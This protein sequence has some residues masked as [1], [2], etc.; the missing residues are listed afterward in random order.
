VT[1]DFPDKPLSEDAGRRLD[2]ATDRG[3]R[4]REGETA[5]EGVRRIAHGRIDAALEQLRR[6]SEVDVASA[7]HDTRKDLKKLRSLLRLVRADLGKREYR[8][9]NGRY[10]DAARLLAVARDAEVKLETLASLRERYPDEAPAAEALQRALEDERARVAGS[11]AAP[12]LRRRLD[13][14]VEAIAAGAAEVDAWEFGDDGFDLLRAGL[15]RSYRRGRD[16]MR[17]LGDDPT[18]FELHEWRKRVKDLWYQLRLLRPV[19]PAALKGPVEAADELADLLGDHHDLALLV[20]DDRVRGSG[21]LDMAALTGL[22]RRRQRE[23][24][25]AALPLGERLYAEKPKRFVE[26]VE[27]Y[28]DAWRPGG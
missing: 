5:D 16:G 21:D 1:P 9:E 10:R 17:S 18:D 4:L 15:R 19:W 3:Y 12:E 14:A 11:A 23:L 25:D 20:D 27:A 24:L 26:R 28:W 22:A 13:E 2:R 8:A 6:K 7:I